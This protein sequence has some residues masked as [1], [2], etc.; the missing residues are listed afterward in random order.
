MHYIF[1]S[2]SSINRDVAADLK[3]GFAAEDVKCWMAPDDIVGGQPWEDSI[4][5]GISNSAIFLLLWSAP[6]QESVQVK[7]EL[8]LAASKK[9][10]ILPL[11]LDYVTPKGA[12]AYYLTNTHWQD[13]D[14]NNVKNTIQLIKKQL[15][16]SGDRKEDDP[17]YSSI[18]LHGINGKF[19]GTVC[20]SIDIHGLDVSHSIQ[21]SLRESQREH[22]RVLKI[23]IGDEAETIEVKIPHGVRSGTRLR[24]KGKGDLCAK[25]GLR[26]D[27]YLVVQVADR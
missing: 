14:L 20:E 1:I 15:L 19:D 3:V 10:L 18:K 5:D 6:S 16:R 24:L 17:N 25:S 12:F 9:K 2:H 23:G 4:A 26:G 8:S 22:V 21:L 27:L 13:L 7:R 11:K